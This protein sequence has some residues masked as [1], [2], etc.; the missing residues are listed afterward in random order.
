M[1]DVQPNKLSR[2]KLLKGGA[3]AAGAGAATVA[4][5]HVARA[6]TMTLRMQ[7]AWPPADVFH[8]MAE[9]YVSRVEAMAGDRLKIDLSPA[10]A[11]VGAFQLHDAC[12]DGVIDMGHGVAAYWYGK[13]KAASLFGTGP[14]FGGNPVHMLAWFYNGGGQ[15]L[16]NELMQDI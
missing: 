10:G 6:Q 16:Y 14:V 15:E 2:R 12:D 13:N 5:P 1:S 8:E 4:M 3:I 7:S 11:I 9:D